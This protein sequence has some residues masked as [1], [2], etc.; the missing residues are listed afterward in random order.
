MPLV[1]K[2]LL[3]CGVYDDQ[4]GGISVEVQSYPDS[5]PRLLLPS[6]WRSTTQCEQVDRPFLYRVWTSLYSLV[7]AWWAT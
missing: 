7:P 1:R 6:Q 2:L 5:C 3:L 4:V